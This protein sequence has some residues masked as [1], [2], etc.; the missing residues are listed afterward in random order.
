MVPRLRF[1]LREKPQMTP[2][3]VN[4]SRSRI[5]VDSLSGQGR[6]RFLE[7]RENWWRMDWSVC[8]GFRFVASLGQKHILRDAVRLKVKVDG[9]I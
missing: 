6:L 9:I 4:Y 1:G 2:L 3:L 5:L 8:G 7:C